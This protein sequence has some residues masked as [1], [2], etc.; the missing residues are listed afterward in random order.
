MLADDTLLKDGGIYVIR[1]SDIHYYGGRTKCFQTR[2]A[3]HRRLLQ[4][5]KHFNPYAQS[6]YDRYRRFE[7]EVVC[8]LSVR[9]Q[10]EAEREWLMDHFDD[11]VCV[12]LS[13]S[14]DGVHVG[15]HHSEAT[16]SKH[17]RPVHTPESKEKCRQAASLPRPNY[18]PHLHTDESRAKLSTSLKRV[19]GLEKA[20]GIKR[21]GFSGFHTPES[22]KKMSEAKLGRPHPRKGSPKTEEQKA[23]QAQKM[24]EWWSDP[25]RRIVA[26]ARQKGRPATKGMRG[27]NH[28]SETK[29]KMSEARKA[30][31]ARQKSTSS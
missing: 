29:Q 26:S 23:L 7:P 25:K 22:R 8:V 28:S 19:W 27:L 14:P 4:E 21:N 13:R 20:V 6:V 9:E 15:Y 12:N 11:P 31:C 30:Y 5:G 18:T 24:R 3:V 17:R 16:R 2:W 1:L 10:R